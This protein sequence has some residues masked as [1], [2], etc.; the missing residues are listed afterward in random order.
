[1][2]VPTGGYV[3]KRQ[4][5]R[6]A[7]A[8][9]GGLAAV[10]TTRKAILTKPDG[11]KVEV[12][13]RELPVALVTV[14]S[15]YQRDLDQNWVGRQ[16]RD[17]WDTALAGVI[18]V[19]SRAGRMFAVDGM[20]RV[21][22][23]RQCGVEKVWAHVLTGLSQQQEAD[24]FAKFQQKRRAL[25]VWELFKADTTAQKEEALDIARTVHQVGF[26]IERDHR[27]GTITAVGS[28]YK[29]YR[30]GAV[31]LLKDT[32]TVIKRLW[33]LDDPGA[34]RGQVIHGIAIFLHSFQHEPQFRMERLEKVLPETA[35]TKLLRL[36]Q[37]IASRRQSATVGPANVGE[38]L[39]DLYNK[40]IGTD[41]RLGSLR[42]GAGKKLR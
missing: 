42:S 21:E 17:G 14:D 7:Q 19:S 11:T 16:A 26:R 36:A 39:R 35:P 1:M 10:E 2:S 20:H 30:L 4:T 25:K 41:H 27:Q 29:V 40:G 12:P 13:V 23:A 32:L 9:L 8:A 31:D 5:K 28:L 18:T 6:E 34:L 38:A 37:D 3:S 24:L 15:Q 22:L 33:T